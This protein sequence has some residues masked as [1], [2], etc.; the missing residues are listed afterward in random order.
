MRFPGGFTLVEPH[1]LLHTLSCDYME[2][3]GISRNVDTVQ[4]APDLRLNL[5][6]ANWAFTI[7]RPCKAGEYGPPPPE[8][9]I[10]TH[11]MRRRI[12]KAICTM[13]FEQ[14]GGAF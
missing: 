3:R 14:V 4:F 8:C 2:S 13:T 7:V 5:A 1:T 10:P 11:G 9:R 6:V 12:D